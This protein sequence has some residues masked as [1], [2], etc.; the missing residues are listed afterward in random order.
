MPAKGKKCFYIYISLVIIHV[1]NWWLILSIIIN[2][3]PT[4]ACR[5]TPE[6]MAQPELREPL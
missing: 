3:I 5:E 6:T 2:I 4:S 1:N